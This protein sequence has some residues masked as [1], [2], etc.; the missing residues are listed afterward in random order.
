VR[1]RRLGLP[2]LHAAVH[3]AATTTTADTNVRE[4]RIGLSDLH[5]TVHAAANVREWCQQLS[6]L[7]LPAAAATT[8]TAVL[9]GDDV[10][11]RF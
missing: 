7:H 3:A 5:A 8:T 11:V 6:N 9:P 1:Q 10:F 4:R 2:D